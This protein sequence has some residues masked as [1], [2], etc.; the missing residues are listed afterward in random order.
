VLTDNHAQRSATFALPLA[1]I[2][3]TQCTVAGPKNAP[4]LLPIPTAARTRV[5]S[6]GFGPDMGAQTTAGMA[7]FSATELPI[8]RRQQGQAAGVPPRGSG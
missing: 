6:Y 2:S 5:P 7:S 3:A 4:A 8:T 1:P